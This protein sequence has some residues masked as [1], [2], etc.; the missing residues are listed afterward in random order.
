MQGLHD[1]SAFRAFDQ[2]TERIEQAER[3][4]LASAEVT[5]ELTGDTLLS[6]FKALEAGGD[7]AVEDKL[8]EMKASM[9][10]LS[11]GEPEDVKALGSG[12]DAGSEADSGSGADEAGGADDVEEIPEAELLELLGEAGETERAES[13]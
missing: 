9:G 2:M 8:L 13:E 4:A 7:A 12:E 11:S 3:Q 10:L 6:E 1:K 5:E